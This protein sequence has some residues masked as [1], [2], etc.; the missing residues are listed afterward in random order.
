[1]WSPGWYPRTEKKILGKI[2]KA[3]WTARRSNQSILKEMNPEYL[4]EGLMKKLKLQY[5]SHL[6]Q[7]TNSL[8]KTLILLK[9]KGG[10][11]RGQKRMKWLDGIQQQLYGHEFEQTPGDGEGQASLVRCSSWSHRVRCDLA[12]E[13]QQQLE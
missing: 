7:R 11:R 12:T 9:I 6:N 5:F 10:R 2:T 8:E 4:L 3:I 1:M 13:R